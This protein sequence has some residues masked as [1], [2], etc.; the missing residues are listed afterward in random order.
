MI[1]QYLQFDSRKQHAEPMCANETNLT[2]YKH[3]NEEVGTVLTSL[4]SL[5]LTPACHGW[6]T[7]LLFETPY[8]GHT[9]CAYSMT[10]A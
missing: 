8:L 6:P 2:K 7:A 10:L 9:L 3:T 1:D 4:L 5:V